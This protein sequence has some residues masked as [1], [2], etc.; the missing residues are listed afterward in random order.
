MY[1]DDQYA[2]RALKAGAAG[3]LTKSSAPENLLGAIRQVGAGRRYITMQFAEML[4]ASIAEPSDR[5]PHER[6][7]DREFQ[8]LRL[9]ASG[10]KLSEVAAELL[11]PPRPS[12]SSA[13]TC[14]T[15]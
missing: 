7:S 11:C 14:S 8:T 15:S 12:A 4:A 13:P 3:Y 2:L 6:L 10:R 1:P 9:I 5:A